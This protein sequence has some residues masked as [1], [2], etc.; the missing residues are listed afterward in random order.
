MRSKAWLPI[1]VLVLSSLACSLCGR[2]ERA[3]EVGKEAATRASEVATAVGEDVAVTELPETADEDAQE[4]TPTDGAGEDESSP[5]VDADALSELDSYRVR[6]ISRWVPDEGPAEG[7]TVEQ[8]HTRE[9]VAQR[10]LIDMGDG[11]VTELVQI[12]DQAWYCSGG[13]CTQTE[14]D[15]EE[16]ASNFGDSMLLDPADVTGDADATFVGRERMNGI[17]TRHYTL[18]MTDAQAALLAQGEVVN[19]QSDVWVAD[20]PDLPSYT[21][22]FQ[23]TWDETRDE[24]A[25]KSEFLYDIYDVNEPFEIE[26]PE[27]AEGSGLPEDVPL[28]SNAEELFAMEGMATFNSP[29]DVASVADFYRDALSAEGWASQT[30]EQMGDTVQQVWQKEDRTLTL[31]VSREDGGSSVIITIE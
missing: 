15:P 7:M 18:N 29:D 10:F 3:V 28:Y 1:A 27:G 13:S 23:M 17:Q 21:A 8:A 5:E 31:M 16:L 4:V 11:V 12:G 14:A 22:R 20:E 19:I 26:P 25:G 6:M 24:E 2:A 9:P 30:D